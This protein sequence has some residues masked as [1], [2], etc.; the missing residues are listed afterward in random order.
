VK[1]RQRARRGVLIVSFV[2]YPLTF[3]ILSPDLLLFGASERVVAG[4]IL[5][6][7]GLFLLSIVFGRLFCGWACPAGALQELCF[8]ASDK[9]PNPRLDKVKMIVFVPWLGFF[10]FLLVASGGPERVD[11]L[12][13]RAFG[14]PVAG[15]VE[16]AMYFMT[17]AI[18][19]V[20][21]LA[22]GKR[23]LCHVLCWVSPFMI[24]GKKL[25]DLAG[26]RG[27]VMKADAGACS[28]CGACS[29][30]CPMSLDVAALVPSG[31]IAESECVLCGS[32]ADACPRN[33]IRFGLGRRPPRAG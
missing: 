28:R 31:T 11:F 16:R 30:A 14:V 2:L 12:Y 23:G 9:P 33:A 7:S 10:A 26:L 21:S 29:R 27:L 20:L 17:V 19:L 32:C 6:F 18:V 25:R 15:A 24:I 4:D 1:A 22:G 3:F 13:E 5:F 8:A